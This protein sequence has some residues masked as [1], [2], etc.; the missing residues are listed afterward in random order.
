MEHTN[1]HPGRVVN[2]PIG[3]NV[4]A[5]R[6]R[7]GEKQD[8][9]ARILGVSQAAYSGRERGEVPFSAP[10]LFLLAQAFGVDVTTFFPSEAPAL[11]RAVLSHTA[12]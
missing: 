11:S 8:S 9:I 7:R 2:I 1:S 5:E 3:Q 4:R 10:E 12:A 6:V